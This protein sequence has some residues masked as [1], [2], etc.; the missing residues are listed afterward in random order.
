MQAR[1]FGWL[2]DSVRSP[3]TVRG[4]WMSA[5]GLALATVLLVPVREH[6]GL[7]NVGLLY[8]LFVVV[9]AA[10]WGWGPG[11]FASVVANL[12]VNF[13]FVPPFHA[14]TVQAPANVLALLVFLGV[15]ALTSALLARARAGEAAA[16]RREGETAILYELSRLIIVDLDLASILQA[17]CA[18]VE[19][20]FEAAYCA[21]LLPGDAGLA[22]AAASGEPR[23]ETAYERSAAA[24][25]F[26]SGEAVH[27][28]ELGG[29]RPR[30]VGMAVRDRPAPVVYVPLRVAERTLGVLQAVGHLRA[31]VWTA[32]E[33]RLLRA[34]ADEAA[35]ALDRDRLIKE[36]AQA[37]ALQ[38]TDRLKSVL[39][40]GVSHDL[41]TPLTS[42]LAAASTLLQDDVDWDEATRRELLTSIEGQ[43]LRLSRLVSNLLDLSRIEGGALRPEKERYD[44]G[45]MLEETIALAARMLSGHR[46]RLDVAADVG[47]AVFD[48]VQ[49]GQV[50]TNLLENAAK[51]APAGSQITVAARRHGDVAEISVSDEGP[52]IP[53]V[54]RDAIFAKFHR[55]ARTANVPGTGIGLAISRGLVEANGGAIRVEDAPSGGARL[56]VTLPGA[57]R[58][59]EPVLSRERGR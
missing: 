6:L 57:V 15:A 43:S 41:R 17:I 16:R 22:A 5:A 13:F 4:L 54:D 25:A 29:R 18:R 48:Y 50:V 23:R 12:L 35:L 3:T 55:L 42:I 49:I 11:V 10:R 7:L 8:L 20:T 27:L 33:E 14:F 24:Q 36:S 51:F 28:G 26:A 52:G 59:A 9:I 19:E 1:A 32:D 40:A 2:R 21:I 37:E 38:E 56:V 45:E 46:L 31:L 58:A 30:I 34:F 44:V 47:T 53:A 39:L